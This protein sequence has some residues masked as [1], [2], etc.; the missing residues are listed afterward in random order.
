MDGLAGLDFARS[1]APVAPTV[2][3]R[4]PLFV[5]LGC[6]AVVLLLAL[7]GGSISATLFGLLLFLGAIGTFVV[8]FLIGA[9][10]ALAAGRG[11]ERRL[12]GRTG[13]ASL[14]IGGASLAVLIAGVAMAPTT[15]APAP[16][17]APVP[18]VSEV[19]EQLATTAPPVETAP[20]TTEAPVPAPIADPVEDEPAPQP[21]VPVAPEP[22]QPEEQTED[23]AAPPASV[24]YSSC[25]D[26]KAS[27]AAPLHRGEPGYRSGLDRDNDGVACEN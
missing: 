18:T 5:V 25:A 4:T 14:A 1:P 9:V 10:R 16:I 20:P 19:A 26:A 23:E 6:A 13:I 22:S 3:S 15:S 8:R 17:A 27:G 11:G 7:V 24:Y 12:L 2:R 21:E